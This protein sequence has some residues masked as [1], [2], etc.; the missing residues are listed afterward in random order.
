LVVI[1]IVKPKD[2]LLMPT[3]FKLLAGLNTALLLFLSVSLFAQTTVTG[4]VLGSTDKQPIVGA[5]VQVKGGKSATLTGSDGSFSITSSQKVSALIITIVGYEPLTVAVKGNSVG[6]VMLSTSATSLNDVVVTGYTTQKK[7]DLTGAVD[8]VNVKDMKAIQAGSPEQMLQGQASGVT[9][10]TSGAP[11]GPTNV[12]IRGVTSFGNTDPLYIIDG[13]QLPY[14]DINA[15]DIESVQVLKDA[16]ASIFGVRGSN[17]VV[18]ITTKRGKSVGKPTLTFDGYAGTQI[19]LSG[20]PFHLLNAQE[21]ANALWQADITSGQVDTGTHLP[22]SQQ[23]G[24]GATPVLPDYITPGGAKAGSPQVDP[25]LYNT[26]YTKGPIYQITAANKQG[27]DWFHELFKPAPIQSY[28]IGLQGGS[29]KSTYFFSAGYFNQQGTLIDTYLKRYMMRMNTTFALSKGI[30]VGEN[31]YAFYL[32]NPQIGYF[33]ENQINFDYREQAIIPVHDIMGNWAGSNGPELG[34][35]S[36]PVANQ[37]RTKDNKGYSWTMMGNVWGEVDFLKHFTVRTSFGGLINNQY[38][39]AYTYHTYENAENNGSNGYTEG[40]SYQNYYDWINTLTYTNTFGKSNLKVFVGTEALDQVGHAVGGTRINYFSDNL[41]LRTLSNGDP[42]G[43]TNFSGAGSGSLYSLFAQ[44]NYAYNDRYLLTATIRRDQAS[45]FGPESQTGYFPAF[46]GGWILTQEDFMSGVSWLNFL[47][48]RASWG[49]LGSYAN[50]NPLN[51]FNLYGA[52]AGQSYYDINGTSSSTVLGF[53]A[54]QYGSPATGWEQDVITNFGMDAVL[55]KN[56]IEFTI[57]YYQKKINGLLFQDNAAATAGAFASGEPAGAQLPAVNIGDVQNNG[58]DMSLTYHATLSPVSKLNV[59]GIFTTYTS[60][61]VSIPNAG[62]YFTTGS[63]RI[64]DFVRNQVGQPVGSFY[65]YQVIGYFSGADDVAKS[66]V[67]QD[68]APGRFKYADINGDGKIDATDRT[69]F[70]NPNPKFTYG[71]NAN[72]TVKDFDFTALFYGSYG[73]EVVNYQRYWTDMWAS[74]QG[75]KS[76][77]L[78]YN[79]WT[80]TNLNPKAPILENAS[81]FSTNTVP[82]SFYKENGSFFKL[83]SLIVGYTLPSASLKNVGIDRLRVY[84]QGSNLFTIT[85]YTGLDPEI[86]G[87]SSAFGIDYGQ[88]PGNQ[89]SYSVGISLTF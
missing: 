58:I 7:K 57:E 55:I 11:G 47:K 66:P 73:N 42:K 74:F 52:S 63:T 65:G 41:N 20:N 72:A 88:Y 69:F 18:I 10:I 48:L 6:D 79:S 21:L 67:Q 5:T 14:H 75:N 34:N 77:N 86:G 61:V 89:K 12:F 8:V 51:Q 4:R 76:I 78:L 70:G 60:K 40:A 83:R 17:G 71:I 29:D 9:V 16:S 37:E 53:Q 1:N 64:G 15:Q 43:Q 28:N 33:S 35:A 13:V 30:R 80:P 31:F 46:S 44:A 62:G 56:K 54:S 25:S 32:D 49:K 38:N 85:G 81:T 59:T 36:N 22:T 26:D 3:K 24:N 39:W 19:P 2:E 27:T 82:N 68:A 45:V 23:Y 50:V 87:N 84:V